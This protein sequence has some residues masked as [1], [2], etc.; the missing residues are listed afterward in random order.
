MKLLLAV[1][2]SDSALT[3]VR[4]VIDHRGD[5]RAAPDLHVLTVQPAVA[6]GLVQ[7]LVS[8]EAVNDYQREEGE[9][10]MA[11]ARALLDAAGVSA[12]QHIGVGEPAH[13]IVA[14]ARQLGADAIVMGT[15]GTGGVRAV[16]LGSTARRVLELA[17]RPV[18]VVP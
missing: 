10:A 18:W 12:H 9:A 5:W 7:R 1:D 14:H 3:A 15:R 17:D 2:G 8:A 13:T 6:S 4:W 11:P 16:L